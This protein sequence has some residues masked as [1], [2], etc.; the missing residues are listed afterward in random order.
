MDTL[1]M[2]DVKITGKKDGD[3]DIK[4]IVGGDCAY[5]GK[6]DAIDLIT[7]LVSVFDIR[8]YFK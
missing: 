2:S 7:H 8:D 1:M 3:G 5:I 6:D 4:I